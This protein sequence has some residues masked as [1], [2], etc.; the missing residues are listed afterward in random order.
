MVAPIR[1]TAGMNLRKNVLVSMVRL[2]FVVVGFDSSIE[3]EFSAF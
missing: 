2:S 1:S 3:L